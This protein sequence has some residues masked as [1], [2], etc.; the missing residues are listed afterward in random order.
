MKKSHAGFTLVELGL[1]L[2]ILS[3]MISGILAIATQNVRMAKKTELRAKMDAIENAL[4]NYRKAQ[5]RLPCPGSLT[6][7]YTDSANLGIEGA[8]AGTCTGGSPA[9]TFTDG[10]STVGGIVPVRALGLTDDHAVDPWG[11]YFLYVVDRRATGSAAFTTYNINNTL[12]GSITIK[13]NTS[14]TPATLTALGVALV[15]SFGPNGHGAYQTSGTR[16]YT[17]STNAHEWEN[18]GCNATTA[19][20]FNATFY[21]H[22]ST[23]SASSVLDSFDDEVRYYTRP[24]F[25]SGSSDIVTEAH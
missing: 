17:G 4:R 14:P 10:G 7:D 19:T 11:N 12:I 21:M 20:T 18:C 1:V 6:V 23:S 13:D 9:A 5:D 2:I 22:S 3:M 16:K 24:Q 8:T 25:P 15:A